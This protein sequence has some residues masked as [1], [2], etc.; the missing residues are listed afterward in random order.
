M[1]ED[2]IDAVISLKHRAIGA[3]FRVFGASR[4]HRLVSTWTR[5]RGAI[6]TFHHV[7]PW[8][9]QSFAPN[10]LLE[11]TPTFLDVVLS[12]VKRAGYRIV[13]MDEVL[14]RLKDMS[15]PIVAL[16]FDDGYRD[17]V[18]HALP[19][20]EHHQAPFTAYAT[21]GF[22]DRSARLWWVELADAIERCAALDLPDAGRTRRIL[23][24][25]LGE[26]NRAF[27]TV[28]RR[29]QTR[30]WPDLLSTVADIARQA[31]ISG[32]K[33]VDDLCLDWAELAR[34]STHPLA[35]VG[36]H[37]STHPRLSAL[38]DA[39][40]RAELAAS[41]AELADRLGR[42]IAHLCY[43]YGGPNA[44]AAREFD[45]ARELGFTTAVTTR[46]GV[47][48]WGDADH[49]TALPRLSV[50]GLWQTRDAFE[51]L[52]SGAATAPWTVERRLRRSIEGWSLRSRR[53]HPGRAAPST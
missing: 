1:A 33:I 32:R 18:R 26:K 35:T 11:I 41:R 19:V 9:G 29:V 14:P 8:Q 36:C 48:S 46:P 30:P 37:T 10:R 49:P 24:G 12:H 21:T 51:I 34:L 39:Q 45:L 5:G 44:A 15:G 16:T 25:T 31:G 13:P 43:P 3:G 23:T 38:E 40:A 20:L 2:R 6:L 50:N 28:S 4:I 47:L 17:L 7:R 52:L 22:L 27:A 42:H 53:D